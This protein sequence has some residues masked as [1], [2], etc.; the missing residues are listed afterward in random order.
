MVEEARNIKKQNKLAVK[1]AED[2]KGAAVVAAATTDAVINQGQIVLRH[3]W[4]SEGEIIM[5]GPN[6]MMLLTL[7]LMKM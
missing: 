1:P 3:L 6:M 7:Q 5:I 2:D 4:V